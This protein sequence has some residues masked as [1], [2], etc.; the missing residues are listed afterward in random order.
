MEVGLRSGHMT[1]VPNA[2][3]EVGDEFAPKVAIRPIAG[4][5]LKSTHIGR[6]LGSTGTTALPRIGHSSSRTARAMVY[7]VKTDAVLPM[8][9]LYL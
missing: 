1:K 7:R 3:R 5:R 4:K 9:N 6:S 2:R 8:G